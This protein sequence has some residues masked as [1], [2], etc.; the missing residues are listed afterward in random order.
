MFDYDAIAKLIM[1]LLGL[2]EVQ[3]IFDRTHWQL[4]KKHNNILVLAIVYK[5][6]GMPIFWTGSIMAKA[7]QIPSDG[8]I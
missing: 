2:Q 4:G 1:G 3:L 6:V 7:I 8:L 5:G